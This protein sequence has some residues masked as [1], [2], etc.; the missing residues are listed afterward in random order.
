[1]GT[2][3]WNSELFQTLVLIATVGVTLWIYFARRRENV[4]TAATI[5]TLQIREIEQNIEYLLSEGVIN[6]RK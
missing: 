5:L 2:T 3:F 6:G 4:R 1:M